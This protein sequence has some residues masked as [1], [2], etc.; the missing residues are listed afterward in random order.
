[1]HEIDVYA[2][3]NDGS[4]PQKLWLLST[5]QWCKHGVVLGRLDTFSTA[6][7]SRYFRRDYRP[8]RGQP[9]NFQPRRDDVADKL[10]NQLQGLVSA[11]T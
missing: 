7:S 11:L 1:M 3:S 10:V 8:I 4:F 2:L 9:S 6:I 5:M